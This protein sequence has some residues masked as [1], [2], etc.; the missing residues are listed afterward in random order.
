MKNLCKGLQ[1][2]FPPSKLEYADF[3]LPFELLFC[4]IK[5]C[6]LTTLQSKAVKSKLLDTA[7]SSF[8]KFNKNQVKSSLSKEEQ[9]ALQNL[10]KQNHLVIQKVDKGNT[11][12]I[13]EK[14]AY[15]EKM[16]DLISD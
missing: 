10:H 12:V 13:T 9:E 2:A 14:K 8:D 11:A 4:D 15:I 5:N 7:F 1:F 6:N 3:M 16:K